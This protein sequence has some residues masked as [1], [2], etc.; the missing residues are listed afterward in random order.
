MG[1]SKDQLVKLGA[2]GL[3]TLKNDAGKPG[4]E[5]RAHQKSNLR[6]ISRNNPPGLFNT[7]NLT[8]NQRIAL[9]GILAHLRIALRACQATTPLQR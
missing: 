5:A 7:E 3:L 6:I 9:L 1:C 2:F 4:R 8:D